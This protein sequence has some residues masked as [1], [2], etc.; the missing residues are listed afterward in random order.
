MQ[1]QSMK[2]THQDWYERLR[3]M[4]DQK[5]QARSGHVENIDSTD[6]ARLIDEIQVFQ[7]EL[8]QHARDLKERNKEL[9]CLHS[10]SRLISD[11]KLSVD[12]IMARSIQLLTEAFQYPD[13]ICGAI[14]LSEKTY[15]TPHFHP[16]EQH[17]SRDIL[18][19]NRRAGRIDIYGT[20]DMPLTGGFPF[21]EEEKT[22]ISS[23]ALRLGHA[24]ERI[25][26][27]KRILYLQKTE[28][29]GR[30]AGAMAHHYNNLLTS[31]MGNLEMAME[32]LPEHSPI[33]VNLKQAMAAAERISK[34][35]ATMLAYLGQAS[36]SREQLDLSETCHMAVSE[37]QA[38][39]PSWIDLKT[40]FPVPGPAV[41]A[42][43]GE[44]VQI[45]KSL[46]TNAWEAME[47]RSGAIDLSIRRVHPKEIPSSQRHPMDF[48]PAGAAFAC[49]RVHDTGPGIPENDMEKI[50]DP[51]YSTRFTGRGLGLPI[52]LGTA[53]SMGGCI[54]VASS[55]GNGT[56]FQVFIPAVPD[57]SGPN[58]NQPPIIEKN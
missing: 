20:A 34:L 18:V 11:P 50:F 2:N 47:D 12:E 31:V 42:N 48:H 44:I 55:P 54:T 49:I 7:A 58:W 57:T 56:V 32:D 5:D 37:L 53:K 3:R 16:T 19:K 24:V 27:E 40:D 28:S 45:V 29:L 13:E 6:L 26:A 46:I 38:D 22:L 30:M 41:P 33:A 43:A 39:I 35:G 9:N 17:L 8:K 25:Q 52:A 4:A 36:T 23:V 15:T 10:I 14:T 1:W 51:F 21:L